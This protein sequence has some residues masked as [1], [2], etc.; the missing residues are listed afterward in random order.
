M[1]KGVVRV[2]GVRCPRCPGVSGV[3]CLRR[4]VS[5]AFGVPVSSYRMCLHCFTFRWCWTWAVVLR[6]C[7]CSLLALGPRKSSVLTNQISSTMPW[8]LSGE[9]CGG[10]SVCLSLHLSV[11]LR[12]SLCLYIYLSVSVSLSTFVCLPFCLP[13]SYSLSFILSVCLSRELLQCTPIGVVD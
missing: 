11:C 1:L 5:P 12:I 9:T 13:L 2:P 6:S 10:L 3:W 8:I 7:P 4:L